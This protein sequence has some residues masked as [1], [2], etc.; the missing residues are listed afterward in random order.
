MKSWI[1]SARKLLV[2]GL[3]VTVV[4]P[5]PP[6]LAP[7]AIPRPFIRPGPSAVSRIADHDTQVVVR[8]L[9]DIRTFDE[10]YPSRLQRRSIPRSGEYG[11]VRTT[12]EGSLVDDRQRNKRDRRA[13]DTIP[14]WGKIDTKDKRLIL[15]MRSLVVH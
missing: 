7:S 5:F 6:P 9:H 12:F 15:S 13:T 3:G 11:R 10:I 2:P 14:A 8:Y 4:T 1:D